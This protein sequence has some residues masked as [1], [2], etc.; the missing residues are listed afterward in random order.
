MVKAGIGLTIP[1][2]FTILLWA[3]L[4]SSNAVKLPSVLF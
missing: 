4:Y 3:E 1:A 2:P